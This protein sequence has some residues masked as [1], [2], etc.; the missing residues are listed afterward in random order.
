MYILWPKSEV[1]S[2]SESLSPKVWSKYIL[3]LKSSWTL[4]E[5]GPYR[6]WRSALGF[7]QRICS[8]NGK[9][10]SWIHSMHGSCGDQQQ[11]NMSQKYQHQMRFSARNAPKLVSANLC[12]L[13]G[14]TD[15]RTDG[16]DQYCGLLGQ[17]HIESYMELRPKSTTSIC[18]WLVD[19]QVEML[20]NRCRPSIFSTCCTTNPPQIEALQESSPPV[21]CKQPWASC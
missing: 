19:H 12:S 11:T 13:T 3:R 2:L 4:V 16:Q 9:F 20:R 17:P 1:I 8:A 10:K 15:R 7:A 18:C 21:I 5:V 6:L 14:Q